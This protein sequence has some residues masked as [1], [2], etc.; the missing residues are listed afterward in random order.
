MS[1]TV[2]RRAIAERYVRFA[3]DEARGQSALYEALSKYVASR[4]R[5][6]S[7]LSQLPVDRQQPNLLFAAVRL[8]AGLPDDTAA[9]DAAI[10]AH[11]P[12]IAKLMRNRTTQTN[13]P[14]RCAVLLPVFSRLPQPLALLEVGASAGLCL[15]ADKYGFDHGRQT[16][17]AP[18]ATAPIF[19]CD[20]NDLT[21]VPAAHPVIA[22]RAGL[23]LNP[24]QVDK[25]ADSEWLETL[26][27][28]EH[29]ER[30]DRLRAAIAI[31]RR[32][33]PAVTRGNLVGDFGSALKSMPNG[34]TRVV[35]HTAVLAYVSSQSDR[36]DFARHV[37]RSGAIWVRNEAPG[38]FP[39]IAAKLTQPIRKDR[40]LLAVDGEP[41]AWTGPHG[42]SID[43]F[44]D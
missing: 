12:A 43:W 37:Q 28:P 5:L 3:R 29:V 39:D 1:D 8:V 26:V 13:E 32:E 30:R 6:L 21:P 10:A 9:L 2:K 22:W 35:F 4:D 27:W 44:A 17:S 19:S 40:F 31:A 15:L 20:V 24:L 41:V 33:P 14:G 7:F 42:Q 34:A 11:G 23:D 25:Q 18:S 38:V 36:E 16:I